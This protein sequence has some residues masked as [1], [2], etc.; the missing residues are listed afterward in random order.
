MLGG[1]IMLDNNLLKYAYIRGYMIKNDIKINNQILSKDLNELNN[2][3]FI[4]LDQV[5]KEYNLKLYYFKE[6]ENLPRVNIVLGFLKGNDF[7][8][9]LDIGSGRGVFLFPLLKEINN[10]DVTSMEIL[11]KRVELLNYISLGGV[12]NLKV[13]KEDITMSKISNDSYEVITMLEVLE[14]I[15]NVFDAIKNAIRISKKFIIATVPSKEDNNPEHIHLLTKDKLTKMFNE[16]GV[17]NLKFGG[18]NGHLYLIARK[19]D[20]DD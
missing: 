13:I 12:K 10:I 4:L 9:I 15:P 18:V 20:V 1:E 8:K 7:T 3:D 17:Y 6:K 14:H 11:D 16:N 5:A 19:G 2:E